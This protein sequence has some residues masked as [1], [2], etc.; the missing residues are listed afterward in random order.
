MKLMYVYIL[1]CSDG[2][3]YTGVTNDVD[4]RLLE[5]NEG[6]D[7]RSYTF[8]RR[9]VQLVFWEVFQTPMAAIEFE[10]QVKGWSR[11]KKE[12]IING[13]WEDLK[14]L[15]ECKNSSHYVLRSSPFD[16]AQGDSSD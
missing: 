6:G 12:A 10:K 4:N 16:F 14:G 5:H 7:K 1:L 11:K 13:R 8:S 2:S 15:S 3:Y 9:P